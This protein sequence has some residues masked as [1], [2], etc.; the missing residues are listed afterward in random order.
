MAEVQPFKGLV[1]PDSLKGK[2][3]SLT[4]PPYDIISKEAQ[5]EFYKKDPNNV[6]RLELPKGFEGE[7][8]GKNRYSQAASDLARMISEGVLVEDSVPAFYT[9]KMSYRFGPENELRT[10]EGFIGRVRLEE[11]EKKVVYPHERTLAGPK[12]DRMALFRATKASFSQIYCVYSDPSAKIMGSLSS[13]SV[14]RFRCVD[15]DGVIHEV[16]SVTDPKVVSAVSAFFPSTP[17][18]I[19]DGHHRY[20]T[21]L[22]YRNERRKEDPNA[23]PNAPFEFVTVFLVAMENPGLTVLPTHRMVHNVGENPWAALTGSK[24][25]LKTVATFPVGQETAFQK[26]LLE[27]PPGEILFGM[28]GGSPVEYRIVSLPRAKGPGVQALDSYWLQE[29]VLA[30]VLSVTRERVAKE[31]LLRYS[32]SADEVIKKIRAGEYPVAF[33]LRPTGARVVEDVSLRGELMPQKS[34][35]F[36]PKPLTGMVMRLL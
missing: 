2:M 24:S 23:G 4:T 30:E 28:V 9:Y 1:Y 33:I 8:P 29:G 27:S 3:E 21:Y 22:A 14:P 34:T 5:E 7:V 13:A 12:E 11:W 19:A 6:I 17:L 15:G 16:A 26:A 20:E 32:K 10:V 35:Y 36:Y 18:F 25:P 31:D